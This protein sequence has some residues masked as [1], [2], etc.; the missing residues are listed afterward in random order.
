MTVEPTKSNI[1][2]VDG[3]P[4]LTRRFFLGSAASLVA[5]PSILRAQSRWRGNPF[6]LGIASGDPSPDGFVI[7]TRLAP[8]PLEPHASAIVEGYC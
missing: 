7:W 5:A 4:M 8:V 1:R 2:L 3:G 6:S